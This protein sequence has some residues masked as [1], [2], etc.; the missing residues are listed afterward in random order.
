MDC[1]RNFPRTFIVVRSGYLFLVL[2]SCM[3]LLH[4]IERRNSENLE[5]VAVNAV[6]GS[7]GIAHRAT[8][9]IELKAT[10]WLLKLVVK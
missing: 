4:I 6:F 1:P 5:E 8:R 3:Y 9:S 2:P 7:C 10:L